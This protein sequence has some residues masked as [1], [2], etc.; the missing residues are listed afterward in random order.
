MLNTID[1]L[2]YYKR[3]SEYLLKSK[4]YTV[5]TKRKKAMVLR[6]LKVTYNKDEV[7]LVMEIKNNSGID[8]DIDYLNISR[9][10]GNKKRKASYQSLEQEVMYKHDMPKVVENNKSKRFVFVLPKFVLG[11]N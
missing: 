7:Y 8:F 4:P 9:V 1:K 5:A 2:T 10:K 6:L 11:D 3:F